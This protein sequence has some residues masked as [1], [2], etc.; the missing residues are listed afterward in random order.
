MA[1][2]TVA[3]EL[4]HDNGDP[5][6]HAQLQYRILEQGRTDVE[7]LDGSE[8]EGSS[9][10]GPR[11]RPVEVELQLEPDPDGWITVE[12][13]LDSPRESDAKGGSGSSGRRYEVVLSPPFRPKTAIEARVRVANRLGW[14][15]FSPC[16]PPMV[17]QGSCLPLC[18]G[19]RSCDRPLLTLTHPSTCSDRPTVERVTPT[20]IHL[21]WSE[22]VLPPPDVAIAY[23]VQA[24][25]VA[26]DDAAVAAIDPSFYPVTRFPLQRW[27][28]LT[29]DCAATRFEADG[30]LP[31]CRFR[32]R[33]RTC[34]ASRGWHP[35]EEA[36]L[37]PF[38]LTPRALVGP[39][40]SLLL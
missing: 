24:Q 23:E 12:P 3:F 13:R 32:F 10:L 15:S 22:V 21:V 38:V 18:V 39:C 1:A 36:T 27:V 33:L 9:A 4:P 20:S 37:S 2:I 11:P 19:N 8:S 35:E 25:R 5:V 17:T 7:G 30:L 16:S 26:P 40:S 6:L 28:V 29:T 14:S 31:S 34:S